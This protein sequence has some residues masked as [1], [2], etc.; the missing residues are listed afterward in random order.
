MRIRNCNCSEKG[1][2]LQTRVCRPLSLQF[3]QSQLRIAAKVTKARSERERERAADKLL[4]LIA[5]RKEA[6]KKRVQ[7][8]RVVGCWR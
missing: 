8:Q 5:R 3:S 7:E 1:R 6:K 4:A 2:T